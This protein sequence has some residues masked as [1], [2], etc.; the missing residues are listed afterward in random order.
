MG[1]NQL[2]ISLVQANSI[3][4]GLNFN[5]EGVL[6]K[7]KEAEKKGSDLIV[8]PEMF[9]S[10]YQ[11]LDLVNKRSFLEDIFFQVR[12]IAQQT[13]TL[14]IRILIGAPWVFDNKIYNA[15]ISIFKGSMKVVSKKSHLPNYDVFDEKRYFV[16]GDEL[17]LMDLGNIKIGF[18][19]CE[20]AWHSDIIGQLK[21][22]G[23]DIIIIPNGSPY[24]TNKLIDRQK[25]I[26]NRCKEANLPIIYLNLVGGQDDLVFDGG[27]FVFDNEGAIICQFPQF[28]EKTEQVIFEK[29]KGVWGPLSSSLTNI[30]SD[31]SQDYSAIVLGLRDYVLKSHFQKVVIGLSGGIDSTLVAV[32]AVD[33]LGSDNVCC[34]ALPSKF[35]SMGSLDDAR[36]LTENLGITLEIVGIQEIMDKTDQLLAPLFLG[37]KRDV[38]EENIQSRLRAVLLMAFSNKQ[39][40][41]LLSTGNKSEIAV[42][43]STIYGDMA[44]AYNPLKDVYKT[45]VYEL[46]RW[47]NNSSETSGFSVKKPIPDNILL[48][49]PS[50][51]LAFD[52][53]DT[54][55]L[56]SY[57]ELD[58][59]LEHLIEDDLGVGEII[60]KGYLEKTVVKVK[61]LLY[62]SEYKRYQACLGPKI[63]RR[64]FSLGRRMPVVNHWRE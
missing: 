6:I 48:K 33:A 30:G 26:K 10:G 54:D 16:S 60:K 24:E 22:L 21:N 36:Q 23:A 32:M 28:Q 15:L 49:E 29:R 50:A 57:D 45:K 63:S 20:D 38:T 58:M 52:Q 5:T 62:L 2:K 3:V 9:L 51:E 18:P 13:N 39:R 43:Y 44:G 59:I 40:H 41:L 27:S 53:K 19:I 56:P 7:A 12:N 35:N 25:I 1:T 8:F 61:D 4:G 14:N 34:L 11:P 55:S 31:A 46:S 42:G 47:R 37:K 64:P 17:D